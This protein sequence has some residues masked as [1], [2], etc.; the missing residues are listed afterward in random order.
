MAVCAIVKVAGFHYQGLQDDSWNF[1][2]VQ[3]EASIAVMMGSVTAFRTLFVRPTKQPSDAMTPRSPAGNLAHRFFHRFQAL[4]RA[5]PDE[6]H[7]VGDEESMIPDGQSR[8]FLRLPTMPSPI[9]TGIRTFIRGSQRSAVGTTKTTATFDTLD[10]TIDGPEPDYHALLKHDNGSSTYRPF[11]PG[12]RFSP[13]ATM[14]NR[15]V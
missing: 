14:Q 1:F 6:K 5:S 8:S 7:P 10:S 2:W 13:G 3:I 12:Q 11:T 4:A 9:F 15:S